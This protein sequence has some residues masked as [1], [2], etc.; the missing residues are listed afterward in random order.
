MIRPVKLE[1]RSAIE[2]PHRPLRL[3][4]IGLGYWG[5]KLFRVFSKLPEFQLVAVAARQEEPLA[6]A[7]KN[8]PNLRCYP[9]GQELLLD[10]SVEAVVIATQPTTH[11]ALVKQSLEAGKH[12][13]VEKPMVEDWSQVEELRALAKKNNLTVMV[14][15]TI[16][17]QNE[18]L[19]LKRLVL[20]G[21]LGKILHIDMRRLDFG[22]F[23]TD[24]DV[25]WNVL[26]HDIYLLLDLFPELSTLESR[27]FVGFASD[28]MVPKILDNVHVHFQ[29]PSGPSVSL[30][31]SVVA[32]IKERTFSI[33]GSEAL[34]HWEAGTRPSFEII[35]KKAI[36]E[37]KQNRV[38]IAIKEST[39]EKF[40]GSAETLDQVAKMFAQRIENRS[41]GPCGFQDALAATKVLLKIAE[42]IK[43]SNSMRVV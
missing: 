34:L 25:L 15:H 7:K 10:E 8:L 31:A 19:E 12:V 21:V 3:G 41:E 26:Y 33:T 39:E 35:H 29:L 2:A 27:A 40:S 4:L 32:P 22:A 13:F 18:Y 5:T 43:R 38:A 11:F 36:Y 9:S 42:A 23:L 28:H 16:L 30:H 1:S 14:D 37:P 6:T 24:T 17:F 20:S